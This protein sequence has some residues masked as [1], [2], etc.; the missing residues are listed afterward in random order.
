VQKKDISILEIDPLGD[1]K[2]KKRCLAI[3]DINGENGKQLH[4]RH[5]ISITKINLS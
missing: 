1:A 2:K 4:R 3:D 5:T